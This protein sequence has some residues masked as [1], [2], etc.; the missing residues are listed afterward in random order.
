MESF[1]AHPDRVEALVLVEGC[2]WSSAQE[3]KIWDCRSF[4]NITSL[5][6]PHSSRIRNLHWVSVSPDESFV[7]SGDTDGLICI[8]DIQVRFLYRSVRGNN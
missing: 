7:W 2:V 6:E 3:I 8:W 5:K 4:E 1:K